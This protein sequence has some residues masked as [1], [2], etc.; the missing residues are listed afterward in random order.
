MI[1]QQQAEQAEAAYINV[2]DAFGLN[3]TNYLPNSAD[4]HPNFEGYRQMANSFLQVY[5]GS[6]ALNISSSELPEP[7]PMSFEDILKQQSS[8]KPQ[9]QKVVQHQSPRTTYVIQGFPGYKAF[10]KYI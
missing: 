6:G 9:Q 7:N 3:A 5:S 2:Y 10:I 4:V 1:L 8:V